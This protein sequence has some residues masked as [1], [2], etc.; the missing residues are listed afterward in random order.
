ME[1]FNLIDMLN[2][3]LFPEPIQ[4]NKI[5]FGINKNSKEL[6]NQIL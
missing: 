4:I 2:I 5:G 3:S 1:L 6:K